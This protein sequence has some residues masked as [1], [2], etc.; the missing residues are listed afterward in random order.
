MKK[1]KTVSAK[2][3]AIPKLLNVSL[4]RCRTV[5]GHLLTCRGQEARQGREP[6]VRRGSRGLFSL[7]RYSSP[8]DHKRSQRLPI[9]HE[10]LV[11]SSVNGS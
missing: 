10:G 4:A 5:S 7:R 11:A 6:R 1:Q 9:C 8:S 2:A 3:K